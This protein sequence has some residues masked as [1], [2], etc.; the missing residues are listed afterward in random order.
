MI[1]PSDQGRRCVSNWKSCSAGES[2]NNPANICNPSL[3]TE[4]PVGSG[5]AQ[6]PAWRTRQA[7]ILVGAMEAEDQ[8]G[9]EGPEVT[10]VPLVVPLAVDPPGEPEVAGGAVGKLVDPVVE[11]VPEGP[12]DPEVPDVVMGTT[13]AWTLMVAP[14][15]MLTNVS[16]RLFEPLEGLVIDT[17]ATVE[18]PSDARTEG[19]LT[20]SMSPDRSGPVIGTT[21]YPVSRFC[22]GVGPVACA[23]AVWLIVNVSVGAAGAVVTI[24][25][26]APEAPEPPLVEPVPGPPEGTVRSSRISRRRTTLRSRG[27]ADRRFDNSLRFIH[28]ANCDQ[29]IMAS[30]PGFRPRYHGGH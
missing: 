4:N 28:P 1:V 29:I 7:G 19:Q 25:G 23:T 5:R 3:Q 27:D 2:D 17:R 9:V 22:S 26:A 11:K 13:V 10:G 15:V 16:V 20:T 6:Q 24:A 21:G 8:L 30:S 18:L 12:L 14:V